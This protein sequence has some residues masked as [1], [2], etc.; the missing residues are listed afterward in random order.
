[1]RPR[2]TNPEAYER[3]L[4]GY[5]RMT[6]ERKSELV[7][8]LSTTVRELAREGIRS[9]HPDYGDDDVNRALALVLYGRDV[10]RRLWPGA[11][12]PAP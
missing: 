2:D 9:R 11:E 8:E 1:M 12:L 7:A 10:F 5:R 3:Q 6:P 4:D